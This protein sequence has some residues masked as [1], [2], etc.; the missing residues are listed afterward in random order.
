MQI[1]LTRQFSISEV[2]SSDRHHMVENLH[3]GMV[4]RWT[5]LVPC[6]YSLEDADTW[7]EHLRERKAVDGQAMN[8]AIR[9]PEG[10]AIGGIGFHGAAAHASHSREIGYW[11]TRDY[12]GRGIM[13][14]AVQAVVS[15]AF[16]H[17]GLSRITAA[18]FHGNRASAKVLEKAGFQVEAPRLRKCYLKNGEL[19][20]AILYAKVV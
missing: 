10:R 3:D 15:H 19:I 1:E 9:N 14:D 5:L 18:V 20:D 11:I 16:Q 8:W 7:L 2:T 6:P 17:F 13:T 12:W 4:Q